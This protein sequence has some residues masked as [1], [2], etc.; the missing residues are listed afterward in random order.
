MEKKGERKRK[1]GTGRKIGQGRK[2]TKFPTPTGSAKPNTERLSGGV[3]KRANGS[4]EG[5]EV[6]VYKIV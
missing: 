3:K 4:G 1:N 2:E 5:T 6:L